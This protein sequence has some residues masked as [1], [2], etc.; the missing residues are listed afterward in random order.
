MFRERKEGREKKSAESI[1]FSFLSLF[2]LCLTHKDVV[3]VI[4]Y[5]QRKEK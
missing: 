1:E 5:S 3:S 4:I 2:F